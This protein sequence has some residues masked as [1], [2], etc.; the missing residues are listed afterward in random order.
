L[1]SDEVAEVLIAHVLLLHRFVE[2][3]SR[4]VGLCGLDLCGI[5][6]KGYQRGDCRRWAGDVLRVGELGGV[7]GV[8]NSRKGVFA[9]DNA[10]SG[11]RML[12]GLGVVRI[13]LWVQW[14]VP[15]LPPVVN[16]RSSLPRDTRW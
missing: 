7:L 8:S 16:L 14:L 15:R 4:R 3:R 13:R 9:D 5:D 6:W 12:V 10:T 11:L 2:C 1:A